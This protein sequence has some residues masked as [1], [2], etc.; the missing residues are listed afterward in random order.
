MKIDLKRLST[1]EKLESELT[2]AL[3]QELPFTRRPVSAQAGAAAS[4]LALFGIFKNEPSLLITKRTDHVDHHKGQMA[5]PGG[6]REPE[7]PDDIATALRETDEETGISGKIIEVIGVLPKLSTFTGFVVTPVIGVL[8]LSTENIV[9]SLNHHEIEEAFWVPLSQLLAPG[10]YRE[11]YIQIGQ[12]RYPIAVFEWASYRIWGA[13][14]V[15][16]KN[17]LDRLESLS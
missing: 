15:M 17:L 4:V 5:F 8:L 11:E 3:A 7:D 1:Q 10:V 2:R 13:T 12:A 16:I 6:V 9:L 14:G